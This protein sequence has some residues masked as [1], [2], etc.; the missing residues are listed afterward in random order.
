MF[1]LERC[2]RIHHHNWKPILIQQGQLSQNIYPSYLGRRHGKAAQQATSRITAN[3]GQSWTEMAR[4]NAYHAVLGRA[5]NAP[6]CRKSIVWDYESVSSNTPCWLS[7]WL[8]YPY[9]IWVSLSCCYVTFSNLLVFSTN[10][11]H[12]QLCF[13]PRIPRK[14][15]L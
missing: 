10:H 1:Y 7:C 3:L 2:E 12:F 15:S 4:Q 8:S 14:D 11:C 13:Q 6:E 9:A 5:P